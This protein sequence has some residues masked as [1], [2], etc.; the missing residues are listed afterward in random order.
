[1]RTRATW[2]HGSFVTLLAS[3]RPSLPNGGN[4]TAVDMSRDGRTIALRTYDDVYVYDVA[5][6][7]G[8]ATALQSLP[9]VANAALEPQGE[10][11]A[12]H[13]DDRGFVTISEGANQPLNHRDA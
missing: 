2:P 7:E 10:A 9:C 13:A 12:F 3:G 5:T 1:M 11:I 4:V 8:A 6:G